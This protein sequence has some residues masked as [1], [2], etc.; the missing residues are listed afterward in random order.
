LNAYAREDPITALKNAGYTDLLA[1]RVGAS[2]YTYVFKGQFGYLDHALSNASLTSQVAGVVPWHINADEPRA[3]DYNDYNQPGLYSPDAY[4]SSD[5]DPVIVG[6]QLAGPTAIDL[7]NFAVEA[8]DGRVMVTWETGTEIDNAGFNI[9]RAASQDGPW[10]KVNQALIA[11]EG[12]PVSGAVYSLV[13]TPG[14]GLFYYRLED[15]DLSGKATLHYTVS[16]QL[17]PAVVAPWFRPT[18]PQF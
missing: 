17:G 8:N 15:I 7:A 16:A 10:V 5:H 6:L 12:D 14:R 2:A 11:A 13:D 9:Y 4:R 3:L 18:M 1:A